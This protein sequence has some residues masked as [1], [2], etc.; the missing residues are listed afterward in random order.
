MNGD[1]Q[2]IDDLFKSGLEGK[3]DNPSPAVWE[4]IE[5]E[6]DKKDSRP[7]FFLWWNSGKIVA[8]ALI[9]LGSAGLFAGGYYLRGLRMEDKET[10]LKPSE[11]RPA[12]SQSAESITP[13]LL[14]NDHNKNRSESLIDKNVPARNDQSVVSDQTNQ[15]P[16]PENEPGSNLTP[17]ENET[18]DGNANGALH[19]KTSFGNNEI[20]PSSNNNGASFNKNTK[21]SSET[22]QSAS[23]KNTRTGKKT[24]SPS[25]SAPGSIVVANKNRLP[26]SSDRNNAV[27]EAVQNNEPTAETTGTVKIRETESINKASAPRLMPLSEKYLTV[28]QKPVPVANTKT[29]ATTPTAI[30]V[31]NKKNA[32][33][34]LPRFALTPVMSWQFGSNRIVANSSYPNAGKVKSEIDRT[35]SQPSMISG[36][37]LADLKI[38]K[39]MTL[40]SGLIFTS[41]TIEIEP[42]FIKA[43]RNPDGKVRYKFDCSAGTYYIKKSTYARP[44]DS[45]LTQFSTNELNYINIPLSL[46]YHFGGKK[47]HLFAMAGAGLNILT[48]QYLETGLYNY[49]YDEKESISTNLKSN[50]FNGMIGAGLN[51][52]AFRKVSFLFSPQYQFAITP[53]NENMPVKAYPRIFNMQLGMQI[54]L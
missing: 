50:Y 2:H 40:Q 1:L 39:N 42:K 28:P 13:G 44:G 7:K 51:W 23:T 36:G 52:Q 35:E 41:R 46:T 53:M 8:A 31:L 15:S 33:V 38:A 4:N 47:F 54:R 16:L 9:I 21:I 34:D 10:K 45:A 11:K 20:K 25:V 22:N 49:A 19:K 3:E 48:D 24:S 29:P 14:P 12:S 5:K 26:V 27:N 37:L 32:A 43:E 6:L 18:A 30:P 17:A